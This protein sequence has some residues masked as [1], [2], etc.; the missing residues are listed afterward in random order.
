[1]QWIPPTPF[2]RIKRPGCEAHHSRHFIVVLKNAWGCTS[3]P[4]YVFL[5]W[6]L[7]KQ[8]GNFAFF[9]SKKYEKRRSCECLLRTTLVLLNVGFWNFV[10]SDVFYKYVD[11][12]SMTFLWNWKLR[13]INWTITDEMQFLVWN[14][15]LYSNVINKPD[16]STSYIKTYTTY[17]SQL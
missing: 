3:S 4:L 13:H 9:L 2:Q 12:I 8:K 14:L 7:I 11:N 6:C 17:S 5:A 1:M 15:S 10:R 16:H